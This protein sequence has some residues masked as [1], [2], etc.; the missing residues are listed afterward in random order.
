MIL[1]IM[2]NLRTQEIIK[3]EEKLITAADNSNVDFKSNSKTAKY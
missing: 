3:K 1:I 2:K